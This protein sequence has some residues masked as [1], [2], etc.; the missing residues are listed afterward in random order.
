MPAGVYRLTDTLN[1][2]PWHKLR[3][4]G[5]VVL[6]FSSIDPAKNGI[7]CRNEQTALLAGAAK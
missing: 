6:D 3:S 5:S 2:F 7:V 1:I 4:R